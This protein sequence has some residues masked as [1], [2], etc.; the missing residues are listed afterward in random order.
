MTSVAKEPQLIIGN[1]YRVPVKSI[2]F[3]DQKA[4]ATF[5]NPRLVAGNRRGFSKEEMSELREAIRTEGLEH[6]LTLRSIGNKLQLISGER[7]L[8]CIQKLIKDDS[9]CYNPATKEWVPAA[10]LYE[11]VEARIGEHDDQTAWKLAY[12]ANDKAIGI[13]ERATIAL[14]RELRAA[15]YDDKQIMAITGKSITWLKDTDLLNTLDKDTLDALDGDQINRTVAIELAK[16]DN[17]AQRLGLLETA[18]NIAVQ[19]LEIMKEK[20]EKE[21]AASESKADMSRAYAVEAEYNGQSKIAADAEAKAEA[22]EAKAAEKQAQADQLNVSSPKVT[23][24]D[25]QK[26]KNNKKKSGGSGAKVALTKAKIK[27]HWLAPVMETIKSKGVDEEG[28]E[29]PIDLEDA[30]LVKVLCEHIEN[31]EQ[32]ILKI[33]TQH[34]KAKEKRSA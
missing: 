3:A 10:E 16:I 27:K 28:N 12:S 4:G 29:L 20:L 26:A 23:S 30:H 9:K 13:G 1:L 21:V 15:N 5:F 11:Y 24:K 32:D 33:L 14:V 2:S 8:R 34:F 17:I 18:R 25:L 6:P 31:G 22:L 19:R 7:R